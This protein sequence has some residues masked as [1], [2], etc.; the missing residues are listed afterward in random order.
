MSNVIEAGGEIVE[1]KTALESST[2][3]LAEGTK[4]INAA[5]EKFADKA[6]GA[7]LGWLGFLLVFLAIVTQAI[8]SVRVLAFDDQFLLAMM[9]LGVGCVVVGGAY[10]TF[11]SIRALSA[12]DAEIAGLEEKATSAREQRRTLMDRL[13]G[14]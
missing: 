2:R 4:A 11:F 12:L 10:N 14:R 9:Y 13:S 6:P 7:Q 5:A 1:A 8:A 3:A